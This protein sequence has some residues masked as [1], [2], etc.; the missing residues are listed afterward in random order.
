MNKDRNDNY[1]IPQVQFL[2]LLG[3]K[4]HFGKFSRAIVELRTI[5]QILTQLN[6]CLHENEE[7]GKYVPSALNKLPHRLAIL[8]AK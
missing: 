8:V 1:V 4:R 5:N 6:P 7:F 2:L 3:S